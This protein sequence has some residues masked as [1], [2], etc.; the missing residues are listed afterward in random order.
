VEAEQIDINAPWADDYERGMAAAVGSV[1]T[2]QDVPPNFRERL[3]PD[4]FGTTKW[5]TAYAALLAVYDAAGEVPYPDAMKAL[6]AAGLK[7]PEWLTLMHEAEDLSFG[8]R[9]TDW[10]VRTIL[11]EAQRRGLLGLIDTAGDKLEGGE[12]PKNVAEEINRGLAGVTDDPGMVSDSS[13]LADIVL[14]HHEA[15][16]RGEEEKLYIET[17]WASLDDETRGLGLGKMTLLSGPT[18]NGKTAVAV[19]WLNHISVVN[20]LPSLFISLEM[21]RQDILD[22]FVARMTGHSL[23]TI[24][25]GKIDDRKIVDCAKRLHESGMN[26]TDNS[27]RTITQ[28]IA[29]IERDALLRGTKVVVLD[30]IAEIAPD[31]RRKEDERNDQMYTRW[32]RDLRHC[33]VQHQFHIVVLCQNNKEGDLAESKAMSHV[34]DN[35]LHFWRKGGGQGGHR[36][37]VRKA[38]ASPVGHTY[39]LS[40]EGETQ[41]IRDM[42]RDRK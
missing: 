7:G 37:A 15:R 3:R 33:A 29:L 19:N 27:R 6:G 8:L 41:T 34:A 14:A 23:Q 31:R 28:V 38:R 21:S 13:D 22:R 17:G 24:W 16:T 4:H 30:Y 42:G 25:N 12:S 35:W 26:V 5:A 11:A 1:L 9:V 36:M 32:V 20:Q 2:L 39:V 18:G 40:F 10:P